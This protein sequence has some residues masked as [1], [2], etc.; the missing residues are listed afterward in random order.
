MGILLLGEIYLF[1]RNIL[2]H[3]PKKLSN[4]ELRKI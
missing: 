3:L 2:L 1:E 4:L